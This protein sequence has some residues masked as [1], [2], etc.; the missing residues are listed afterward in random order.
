MSTGPTMGELRVFAKKNLPRAF[1]L[2]LTFTAGDGVDVRLC[3]P[4]RCTVEPRYEIPDDLPEVVICLVNMARGM[5]DLE[6]VEGTW[7]EG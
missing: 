1:S 7:D 6:P 4:R 3:C 2:E 5:V